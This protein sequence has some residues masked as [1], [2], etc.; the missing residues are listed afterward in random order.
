MQIMPLI[1]LV[2]VE[3]LL[4]VLGDGNVRRSQ[5]YCGLA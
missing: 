3:S 4:L 2:A 5:R 1:L